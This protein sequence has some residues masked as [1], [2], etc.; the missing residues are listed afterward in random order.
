[1]LKYFKVTAQHQERN[2][3]LGLVKA[4]TKEDAEAY[5]SEEAA[6]CYGLI[7]EEL[8][9]PILPVGFS[10]TRNELIAKK[11]N[12]EAE[13]KR[14]DGILKCMNAQVHIPHKTQAWEPFKKSLND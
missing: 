7:V 10:I 1:M 6:R 12:L 5:Y 11:R 9:P 14:V 3:F 4:H 2:E 8:E 13:L